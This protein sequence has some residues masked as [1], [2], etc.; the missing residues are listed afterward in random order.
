MSDDW[1]PV[2]N[3][4]NSRRTNTSDNSRYS[5]N[6]PSA[7]SGKYS[8][9]SGKYSQNKTTENT[10][11]FTQYKSTEN[12]KN[13]TQYKS[14]ENTKHFTQ[15]KPIENTKILTQNKSNENT[16][17]FTQNKSTDNTKNLEQNK[18][19]ENNSKFTQTKTINLSSKINTQPVMFSSIGSL[20]VEAIIPVEIKKFHPLND[21]WVLWFHDMKNSNWTINGYEQIFQF[22]TI[23]DFWILYNG[24]NDF[25]N[26]MYYLMRLGYPPIWDHEKNINGGAWTFKVDKR[27]LNKF[28]EELS[29]YC[30]GETICDESNSIVGI[31][32]SP[33]IRFATVRVWTNNTTHSVNL[34]KN[35]S[36][37][38]QNNSIAINFTEA[39][40]TINKE[41]TI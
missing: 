35:I 5:N 15:Y 24:I 34:F 29:C 31:S 30:I 38:T 7:N 11:N 14:T 6:K 13:F 17:N 33:K 3:K 27:N 9:N 23:E 37:K 2:S 22:D 4:K 25:T 8:Q 16:K 12:T 32:I 19:T 21:Q 40:F 36:Q 26:G 39:R 10:K 18:S 20:N 28:W 1:I 41:A